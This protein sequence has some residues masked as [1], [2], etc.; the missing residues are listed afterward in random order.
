MGTI[1]LMATGCPNRGMRSNPRFCY[2]NYLNI[3]MR[4]CF[5]QVEKARLDW[6]LFYGAF[7]SQR[8]NS[9]GFVL[10]QVFFFEARFNFFLSQFLVEGQG[11]LEILCFKRIC[12]FD[13]VYLRLI[14]TLKAYL[15]FNKYLMQ[16]V[17]CP[18]E[19]CKNNNISMGRLIMVNRPTFF[20]GL[21]N[22]FV[23]A[24]LH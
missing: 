20:N 5:G 17:V 24:Q 19:K 12:N 14:K 4:I 15:G 9:A 22:Q 3:I 23:Q 8:R 11:I 2:N 21:L 7:F 16:Q 10:R 13:D 6:C 1:T 18:A